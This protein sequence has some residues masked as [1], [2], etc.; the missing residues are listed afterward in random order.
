MDKTVSIP[1]KQQVSE[2]QPEKLFASPVDAALHVLSRT[3]DAL[4]GAAAE[5][6][7]YITSARRW[8][9]AHTSGHLSGMAPALLHVPEKFSAVDFLAAYAGEGKRAAYIGSAGTV[10][11]HRLDRAAG[12]PLLMVISS[13]RPGLITSGACFQLCAG[14]A[15]EAAD[16]SIIAQRIAELSLLPGVVV[17]PAATG[18]LR[19]ESFLSL[20]TDTLKEYLMAADETVPAATKSQKEIFGDTR[21]LLPQRDSFSIQTCKTALAQDLPVLI[22]RAF[23]EFGELTGREYNSIDIH[24]STT[25]KTALLF[26]ACDRPEL[27]KAALQSEDAPA[28]ISLTRAHPL[29]GRELTE[30]VRGMKQV[31]VLTRTPSPER[32][33]LKREMHILLEQASA[34]RRR[35][36]AQPE[37]PSLP[38]SEKPR[39]GVMQTS[40]GTLTQNLAL[41]L[42][43]E[44]QHEPVPEVVSVQQDAGSSAE[45]ERGAATTIAFHY[46]DLRRQAGSITAAFAHYFNICTSLFTETTTGRTLLTLC[47]EGQNPAPSQRAHIL[48]RDDFSTTT[49]EDDVLFLARDGALLFLQD[50]SLSLGF[51]RSLPR[52]LRQIITEKNIRVYFLPTHERGRDADPAGFILGGLLSL[53]LQFADKRV[54][55]AGID[56]VLD[57]MATNGS[58]A[59]AQSIRAGIHKTVAPDTREIQ[60]ILAQEQ[61]LARTETFLHEE[62]NPDAEDAAT[63]GDHRALRIFYLT[64]QKP[65]S[66]KTAV[67]EQP[68]LPVHL[69]GIGDID[70]LRYDYPVILDSRRD[71]PPIRSLSSLFDSIIED[72]DHTGDEGEQRR[73]DLL[74]LEVAIKQLARMRSGQRLD[75][76]LDTAVEQIGHSGTDKAT[77]ERLREL[78]K[79]LK[80]LNFSGQRVFDCSIDTAQIL[81]QHLLEH[82]WQ[83]RSFD[84]RMQAQEY[85]IGLE[86]ILKADALKSPESASPEH[87]QASLGSSSGETFDVDALS[88]L[89]RSTASG[90]RL[91]E[92]RRG[93][94]RSALQHLQRGETVL[95][96]EVAS[97]GAETPA[98][99]LGKMHARIRQTLSFFRALQIARLDIENKYDP[100][101][102]D[103][104]FADFSLLNLSD[105][106]LR[107]VPPVLVHADGATLD[108]V[109]R[110]S[111]LA[112]LSSDLPVKVILT[113]SQ[114]LRENTAASP[115]ERFQEPGAAFT[116][117]ATA[118]QTAYVLQAPVSHLP[119]LIEELNKGLLLDGPA[120]FSLFSAEERN[121]TLP[122]YLLSAA[123]FEARLAPVYLYN[124]AAGTTLVERFDISMNPSVTTT[125]SSSSVRYLDESGE[126]HT[127][128]YAFTPADFLAL[129]PRFAHHFLP[130][131]RNSWTDDMIPLQEF[132]S[133]EPEQRHGKLPFL[134]L[135]GPCGTLFRVLVT[136]DI[137]LAVYRQALIWKQLQETGG[138]NNSYVARALE[139]LSEQF[140]EEK[141]Q[142]RAQMQQDYEKHL[143]RSVSE[144]AEELVSNIAAGLLGQSSL[145]PP[146]PAGSPR[147]TQ[148]QQPAD[149][150]GETP[151]GPEKAGQTNPAA[152]ASD[153]PEDEEDSLS[154]D[155]AWIETPRCT[156]CNECINRNN[157]MFAYDENK[158]A[159]IKDVTA[160]TFR[161]LVES[162]EN[163]PVKI[164]HP[165]KPIDPNEP[166]LEDLIKRAEAFQ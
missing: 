116:R 112:I 79:Q 162:A 121:S 54:D 161:E 2:G 124:P 68:L 97:T 52:Q 126:E 122:P 84:L 64:G 45:T 23:R 58:I 83:T 150:A 108:A 15:Q 148:P 127:L 43:G 101:K 164:I 120:L 20:S 74:R 114:P 29:P 22:E 8:W 163:C 141:Q 47:T 90:P 81:A 133:I 7:E 86:D 57:S 50:P 25:R 166:G 135:A 38:V 18:L 44:L 77:A 41:R 117:M 123:A 137:V 39:L 28:L 142:M 131:R 128:D 119:A 151:T 24:E 129:Q 31:M 37:Q 88:E 93:R 154:L 27:R 63:P 140:E 98:A 1:E 75:H 87:M 139:K 53:L 91:D 144:V 159:Y 104:Y 4:A 165:G 146:A 82:A 59:F 71:Q 73:R 96:P 157:L 62:A 9:P 56:K 95:T 92:K 155:E 11:L 5:P 72:G 13:D 21:P 132:L 34:R 103:A 143:E 76:L 36:A 55:A 6:A 61:T 160:G 66:L 12:T 110:E 80:N 99:V 65:P 149:M 105:N 125:W 107:A 106:E 40:P 70:A 153:E 100:E 94:I 33:R 111:L 109:D 46:S 156:S 145:A 136:Q 152:E 30:A 10:K 69:A 49:L 17:L 35:A 115:E 89:V 16:M 85:A 48:V 67:P 134:L 14:T 26:S 118:L 130:V 32:S 3:C 51:W 113:W 60:E 78:A 102:H 42:L 147:A 138:V 19:Q 158:Q